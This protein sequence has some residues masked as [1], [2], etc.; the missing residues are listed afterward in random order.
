[1]HNWEIDQ[2]IT[3][4]STFLS[5]RA[6]SAAYEVEEMVEMV[7]MV[8]RIGRQQVQDAYSGVRLLLPT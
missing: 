3:Y 2:H 8:R 1:M 5:L 6:A 7:E 4:Y